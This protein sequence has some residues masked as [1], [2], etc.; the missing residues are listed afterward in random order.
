MNS[1]DK[2]VQD[3]EEVKLFDELD[4]KDG[5]TPEKSVRSRWKNADFISSFEFALSGI[6]A[7]IREERNM[8]KHLLTGVLVIVA[9]IFFRVSPEEWLLLLGAIFIV[10]AAELMN[11]A[12]ENVVDLAADYK[13]HMRAKRA[14]DMAAGSVLVVSFF[15]AICGAVIFL[16]KIWVLF[17]H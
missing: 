4:F 5:R 8:R 17:F 15:S 2:S 12:M 10:L 1:E 6:W 16:P 7:A 11:S 9:G 13:F 14:K 3:T